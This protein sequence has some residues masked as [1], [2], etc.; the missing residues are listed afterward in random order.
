[1]MLLSESMYVCMS[2]YLCVCVSASLLDSANLSVTAC[3]ALAE[4][5]RRNTLPLRDQTSLPLDPADQ[6]TTEQLTTDQLTTDQ[7][8]VASV[9]QTLLSKVK[10]TSEN[11]KV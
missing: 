8:T 7:P 4:I 9:V 2:V 6:L 1:M 3:T 5:G 11:T 10:S